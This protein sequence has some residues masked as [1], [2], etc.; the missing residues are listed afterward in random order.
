M[1]YKASIR[2][3]PLLAIVKYF[4]LEVLIGYGEQRA[5]AR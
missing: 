4:D 2:F 3:L 1:D 5:R